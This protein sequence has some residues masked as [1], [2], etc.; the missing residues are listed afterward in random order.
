MAATTGERV[1][2][3]CDGPRTRSDTKY[4]SSGC[5]GLSRRTRVTVPCTG[6]GTPIEREPSEL[7]RHP[8]PHCPSCA[9]RWQT[10]RADG[11]QRRRGYWLDCY[12]C[13]TPVWRPRWRAKRSL[14]TFCSSDCRKAG[15]TSLQRAHEALFGEKKEKAS[16][17]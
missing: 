8:H 12:H 1:C 16:G 2:A 9:A 7:A 5:Y 11:D 17:D 14:Y 13:G 15:W 6:C 4:C 10:N 3:Y